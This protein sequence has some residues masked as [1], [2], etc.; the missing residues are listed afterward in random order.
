MIEI[1]KK[2]YSPFT[3]LE[4]QNTLLK[5]QEF[6]SELSSP[7]LRTWGRIGGVTDKDSLIK[8]LPDREIKSRELKELAGHYQHSTA[9]LSPLGGLSD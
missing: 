8:K 3:V 7:F 1:K 9:E 6:C 4:I 5:C 2:N